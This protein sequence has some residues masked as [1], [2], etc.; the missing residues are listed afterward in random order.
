MRLFPQDKLQPEVPET[1]SRLQDA[2][3]KVSVASQA[4]CV[5]GNSC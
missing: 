5:A 2:G 4:E 3:M 1:I